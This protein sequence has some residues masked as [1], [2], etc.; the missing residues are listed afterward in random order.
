[1]RNGE[2]IGLIFL[3]FKDG[4]LEYVLE[5]VSSMKCLALFLFK[6]YWKLEIREKLAL[7]DPYGTV[8]EQITVKYSLRIRFHIS[9][10]LL[11]WFLLLL[12]ET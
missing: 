11:L 5:P 8:P 12:R 3:F 10:C 4:K 9:L 2:E 1:M 7:I 6:E